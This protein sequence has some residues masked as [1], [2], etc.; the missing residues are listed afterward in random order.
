[1]INDKHY[2]LQR[3]SKTNEMVYIEYSKLDGYHIVPKT[4]KQD[5]IEVNKIVFVSPSLSEKLIKKKIDKKI[6]Y[7]LKILRSIDDDS[8]PSGDIIKKSLV[9]A[10]RLKLSI[11]NTYVKYLGNTYQGL[12]LKKIQIIINQLRLKLY[13]LKENDYQIYENKGKGR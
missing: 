13:M 7:L 5:A 11:I 10:E 2:F 9:D 4:K 12:T 3:D 1:M 8:D 6:E